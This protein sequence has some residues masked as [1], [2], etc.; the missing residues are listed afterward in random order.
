MIAQRL[1]FVTEDGK[2][3]NTLQEAKKWEALQRRNETLSAF[4]VDCRVDL[5]EGNHTFDLAL[6]LCKYA[7]ALAVIFAGGTVEEAL[8]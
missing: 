3:W 7:G 2:I 1:S 4:V 5:P 6:W 8:K